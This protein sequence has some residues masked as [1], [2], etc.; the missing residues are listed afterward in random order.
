MVPSGYAHSLRMA[1]LALVPLSHF[2]HHTFLPDDLSICLINKK[3]LPTQVPFHTPIH[4]LVSEGKL[5]ICSS[6][7]HSC[8]RVNRGNPHTGSHGQP[9][10]LG[11]ASGSMTLGNYF[12][13]DLLSVKWVLDFTRLFLG[14]FL[15]PQPF[16]L[17][18][19]NIQKHWKNSTI[20]YTI[21]L[22]STVVNILS[23]LLD[24]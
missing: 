15:F 2:R 6:T 12:T 4:P 18:I 20:N 1:A 21:H 3:E 14:I 16:I 5:G 10:E 17:K 8:L 24:R 22:A 19:S 11:P 13:P 7:A 9:A 23:H